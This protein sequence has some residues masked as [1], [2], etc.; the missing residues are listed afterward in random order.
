MRPKTLGRL[1]EDISVEELDQGRV[2]VGLP[3]GLKFGSDVSAEKRLSYG[4]AP[5]ISARRNCGT[6]TFAAPMGTT[7][8][9][10][11]ETRSITPLAVLNSARKKAAIR[12][13]G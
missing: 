2:R 4:K 3:R 6:L 9:S 8:N 5:G 7:A 1:G 10:I 12:I 13:F 11:D